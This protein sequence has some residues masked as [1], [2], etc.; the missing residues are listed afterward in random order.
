MA[1]SVQHLRRCAA[2]ALAT[3]APSASQ[4]YQFCNLEHT[5]VASTALAEEVALAIAYNDISQAVSPV[6]NR[7]MSSADFCRQVAHLQT[8]RNTL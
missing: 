1:V 5:E 3:P 4:S 6:P 8:L 7:R 2:P